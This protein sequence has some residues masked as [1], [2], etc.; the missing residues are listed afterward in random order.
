M[1]FWSTFNFEFSIIKHN[2]DN[3]FYLYLFCHKIKAQCTM[4]L[5]SSYNFF[6]I[7]FL[8]SCSRTN[9]VLKK[10]IVYCNKKLNFNKM[11]AN[12]N[13]LSWLENEVFWN[14]KRLCCSNHKKYTVKV[15]T[16]LNLVLKGRWNKWHI[17]YFH[18]LFWKLSKIILIKKNALKTK[19]HPSL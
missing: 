3:T 2:V 19:V 9:W 14:Q 10:S 8:W 18:S 4:K 11:L 17:H 6:W 7:F 13:R 16:V 12:M 15:M 5:F 1:G